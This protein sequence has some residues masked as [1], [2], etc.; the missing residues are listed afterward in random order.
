FRQA[1]QADPNYA[2]AYAGLADSYAM[3]GFYGNIASQEAARQSKAAATRALELDDS[4]VEPRTSLGFVYS[5]FDWNWPAAERE[6]RRAIELDPGHFWTRVW[7]GISLAAQGR[8]DDAEREAK[9]AIELD[10]L[11]HV[12]GPFL[13]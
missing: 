1:I 10:P 7:Y 2:L 4:I 9:R 13:G 5:W 3:L 8:H 6:F 12:H 11:S